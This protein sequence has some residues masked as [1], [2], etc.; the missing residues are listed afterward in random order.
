MGKMGF[1]AMALCLALSSGPVIAAAPQVQ[2]FPHPGGKP[3]SRAVRV[4]DLIFVSGAVGLGADGKYPA[5][6]SI[7]TANALN[8][9][10]AEL[11]LAGATMD[12][13]YNCRVALTNMDNWD[14]FNRVYKT[15]FKPDRLPVRM[16]MGVTSLGGADVEVQCEAVLSK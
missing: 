3:F 6:F 9:V 14:A 15:Y 11:A 12:N 5:D 16:A 10:A 7:Q 13:V 1:T 4:G 2:Y 8:A